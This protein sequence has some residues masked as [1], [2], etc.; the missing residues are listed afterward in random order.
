[1]MRK[2]IKLKFL[3]ISK[4]IISKRFKGIVWISKAFRLFD[5]NRNFTIYVKEFSRIFKDYQIGLNEPEISAHFM[6]F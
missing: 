2:L 1:M 5:T 6:N 4:Q 3:Q